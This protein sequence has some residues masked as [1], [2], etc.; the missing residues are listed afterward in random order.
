MLVIS[1]QIQIFVSEFYITY[2]MVYDTARVSRQLIQ[3]AV[4]RDV[5]QDC[6]YSA[7]G[8][9]SG[10]NRRNVLKMKYFSLCFDLQLAFYYFIAFMT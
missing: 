9:G 3:H 2:Y 7:E 10:L 4:Y 6:L 8:E 5:E 1:F